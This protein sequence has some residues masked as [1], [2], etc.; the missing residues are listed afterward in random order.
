MQMNYLE[1]LS[2]CSLSSRVAVIRFSS[3]IGR[4][5]ATRHPHL[6]DGDPMTFA[7]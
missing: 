7:A 2:E 4:E 3:G 5:Q 1:F 6:A